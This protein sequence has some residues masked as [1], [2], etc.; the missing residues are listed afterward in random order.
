MAKEIAVIGAGGWGT[1]ISLLLVHKGHNVILWEA[2]PDYAEIL[3]QKRENVEFL[4]G[5]KLPDS[6][7]ITDSIQTIASSDLII[8]AVPSQ[9]FRE[10]IRKLQPYYKD[11]PILTATK[12]LELK[13]GKTMSTVIQE[14]LGNISFAVLSG[15]TI[16][17]EIVNGSP[18]AAVIASY[19]KKTGALFQKILSSGLLRL[20]TNND[21]R[22]VELAAAF[23]NVIAIGAGIIDGLKYGTNTKAAYLTRGMREMISVGTMLGG[24][25]ATF[26]GLSGLGDLMTTCF[27]KHSR[28]RSFGQSIIESG[29]DKYIQKTRMVIEGIPAAKS[30]YRITGK[31]KIDAP[32]TRSIYRIVYLNKDPLAEIK[33]LMNRQLKQE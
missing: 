11:Q 2:F 19:D 14:E 4:P 18:A 29:K 21:V 33:T 22:G 8:I 12:G 6:I 32:L 15:P 16:A 20:Y 10:T 13:Q 7:A 5:I 17:C 27:S 30:F 25:A 3:K 28:N 1:T 23:K 9:H 24:R 31:Q 26:Q